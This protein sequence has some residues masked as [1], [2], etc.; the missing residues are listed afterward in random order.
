[1]SSN[2]EEPAVEPEVS[3]TGSPAKKVSVKKETFQWSTPADEFADDV[4]SDSDED[5][6]DMSYMDE[7]T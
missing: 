1:M 2:T 7:V 3:K 4:G 5:D 6:E